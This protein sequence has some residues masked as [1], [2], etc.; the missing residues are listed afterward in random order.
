MNQNEYPQRGS[1]M[2]NKVPFLYF[3][4]KILVKAKLYDLSTTDKY[5]F[6]TKIS[7]YYPSTG[8][9]RPGKERT[10]PVLAQPGSKAINWF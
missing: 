10:G 1:L 5:G 8:E 6:N 9:G 4:T 7:R 2:R 3:F